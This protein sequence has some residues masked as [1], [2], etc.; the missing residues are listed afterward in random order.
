MFNSIVHRKMQR[1]CMMMRCNF[2]FDMNGQAAIRTVDGDMEHLELPY[3][4]G[5]N[6]E[7]HS[8]CRKPSGS[9]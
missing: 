6:A 1:K 9:V 5:G 8:H 3:I 7:L 2:K 4:G